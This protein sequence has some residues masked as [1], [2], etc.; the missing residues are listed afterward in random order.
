MANRLTL[1][2]TT[3]TQFIVR[4][5][6]ALVVDPIVCGCVQTMAYLFVQQFAT[7]EQ[8]LG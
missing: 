7:E 4:P 3:L 8:I 1:L 5:T 2:Q 6:A